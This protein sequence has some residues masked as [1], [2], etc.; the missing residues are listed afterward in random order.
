MF[1]EKSFLIYK[2]SDKIITKARRIRREHRSQGER[3]N[4]SV[5]ERNSWDLN[6]EIQEDSVYFRTK[7]TKIS[8][9]FPVG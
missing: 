4:V 2:A 3:G 1:K 6:C 5:K 8:Q 7:I 9:C